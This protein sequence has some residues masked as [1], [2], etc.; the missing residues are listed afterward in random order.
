V[1]RNGDVL[2]DF[3]GVGVGEYLPTFGWRLLTAADA[4]LL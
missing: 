4:S 3:A 2:A 1:D